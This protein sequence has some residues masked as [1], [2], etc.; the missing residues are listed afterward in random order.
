PAGERGLAAKQVET[1][2]ASR[3]TISETHFE[4][5][6]AKKTRRVALARRP[7]L[8]ALMLS[9]QAVLSGDTSGLE[10]AFIAN[11]EETLDDDWSVNLRPRDPALAKRL[12]ELTLRGLEDQVLSIDVTLADGKEQRMLILADAP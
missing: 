12:A 11:Y 3:L 9:V 5:A 4:Y 7:E 1:P 2:A 6:D 10:A 8:A